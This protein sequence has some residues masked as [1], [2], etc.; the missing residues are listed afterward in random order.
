MGLGGAVRAASL[1]LFVLACVLG[2]A[3]G[4]YRFGTLSWRA[5]K[6]APTPN[7]VEFELVTGWRRDFSWVYVRQAPHP[8]GMARALTD[9]PIVGDVLRVTGLY[10]Q[11][12]FADLDGSRALSGGT[13]QIMFHTGIQI[14]SS[15]L[16]YSAHLKH[17]L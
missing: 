10:D 13:S 12:G 7:T 11:T 8:L 17:A 6:D 9:K 2:T 1:S 3:E 16:V 14:I 4:S 15:F 5:V